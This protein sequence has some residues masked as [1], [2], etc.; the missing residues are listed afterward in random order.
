LPSS[1]RPPRKGAT[2]AGVTRAIR[3]AAGLLRYHLRRGNHHPAGRHFFRGGWVGRRAKGRRQRAGTRRKS[4]PKPKRWP[5]RPETPSLRQ[6]NTAAFGPATFGKTSDRLDLNSNQK[7]R[8]GQS[9]SFPR[10]IFLRSAEGKGD[11]ATFRM[12]TAADDQGQDEQPA[13]RSCK[14]KP[15]DVKGGKPVPGQL[16]LSAARCLALEI[17]RPPKG[18]APR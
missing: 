3:K 7:K 9:G 18:K 16:S 2:K 11:W 10:R 5:E 8:E 12:K 4:L 15:R 14:R 1:R 13:S 17:Q 6:Q